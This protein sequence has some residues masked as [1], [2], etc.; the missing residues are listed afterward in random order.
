MSRK[1]LRSLVLF[2]VAMAPLSAQADEAAAQYQKGLQFMQLGKLDDAQ[3]AL[4]EALKLRG[5][6]AAAELTLGNVLRKKKLCAQA[7]PHY[8][9]AIRLQ[10]DDHFAHGNLGF[11][12]ATTDKDAD[13]IRM[14][15][16][17]TELAPNEV[18][19]RSSLGALYRRA[20]QFDK[21]L[22]HLEKAVQ[23][24]PNNPDA[25]RNYAVAHCG[26]PR[27]STRPPR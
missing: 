1:F 26:R 16:R 5:N 14:L 13:G 17:A 3:A 24:D 10:P 12:Y 23:L 9:A 2:S 15:V 7:I 6:Y 11:C 25:L 20:K 18:Q 4:E 21:A 8:E 19:W 27:T 22:P